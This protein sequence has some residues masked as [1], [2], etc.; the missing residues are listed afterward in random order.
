VS[1]GERECVSVYEWVRK[2]EERKGFPL[3][4]GKVRE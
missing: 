3:A 4:K 2:E 1:G